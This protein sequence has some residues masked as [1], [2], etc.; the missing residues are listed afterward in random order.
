MLA[1]MEP[2]RSDDCFVAVPLLLDFLI[3]GVFDCDVCFCGAEIDSA[4]SIV[5]VDNVTVCFVVGSI[6]IG[7]GGGGGGGGGTSIGGGGSGGAII[8]GA[9]MGNGGGGGACC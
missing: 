4:G 3:F 9:E 6:S 5:G 2:R 8:S 1:I 7:G